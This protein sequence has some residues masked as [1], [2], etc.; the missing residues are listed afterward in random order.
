MKKHVMYKNICPVL[1]LLSGRFFLNFYH[2][3]T[4]AL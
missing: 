1:L 3:E 4:V 2:L